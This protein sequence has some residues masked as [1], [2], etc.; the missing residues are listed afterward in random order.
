M[1]FKCPFCPRIFSTRSAYTQH[2]NWCAPP[3]SDNEELDIITD[4]NDMS[5]DSEDLSE[6]VKF[7]KYTFFF[8]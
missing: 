7:M 1:S 8:S 2:K 5:L 3:V 4:V 6:A